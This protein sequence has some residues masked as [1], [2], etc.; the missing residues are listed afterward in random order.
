VDQLRII[1]SIT[2][3]FTP[4]GSVIDDGDHPHETGEFDIS[5]A[6]LLLCSLNTTTRRTSEEERLGSFPLLE[7]KMLNVDMVGTRCGRFA[8]TIRIAAALSS[9][10]AL[11]RSWGYYLSSKRID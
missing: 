4:S 9:N 3:L 8:L 5:D 7:S 11:G 1:S 10:N 2:S 6:Q